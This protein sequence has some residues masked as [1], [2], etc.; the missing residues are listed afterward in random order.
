LSYESAA[1]Q[2]LGGCVHVARGFLAATMNGLVITALSTPQVATHLTV[3]SP[4]GTAG[5]DSWGSDAL[6][7]GKIKA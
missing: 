3:A 5:K 1:L 2:R 6:T 4:F 7:D